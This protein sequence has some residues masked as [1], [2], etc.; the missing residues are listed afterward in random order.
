MSNLPMRVWMLR[1]F[2]RRRWKYP[3]F[4]TLLAGVI[5]LIGAFTATRKYESTTTILV[6][7]DQTLNP[8]SG[9]FDMAMAF[10]EQLRNFNEILFSRSTIRSLAD[11]L[12]LIQGR[13][14]EIQIQNVMMTVQ[15]NI[16][17]ARL[18]SDCFH[19]N[20]TDIVPVRAQRGAQ[21]LTS[22][23]IQTKLMVQTKQ[24]MLTVQFYEQK[25]IEY[26][27]DYEA[28]VVS[29]VKTMKQQVESMPVEARR[30]YSDMD[31][32]DRA[33]SSARSR[34]RLFE[35]KEK[36]LNSL[37]DEIR[38]SPELIRD[39]RGKQR[40]FDL[41][42][43]ELPYAADLR[44][45]AVQYDQVTQRYQGSYPEV[46]RLEAQIVDLL[47][48]MRAATDTEIKRLR[49]EE[50]NLEDRRS[51]VIEELKKSSVSHQQVQD[52]GS[53]YETR[54]RL[55]EEMKVRLEQARLAEEVASRGAHQFIVLDPAMVPVV[56]SKPNRMLIV[57]SGLV[58]G[59]LIGIVGAILAELLDTTLRS[60]RD[61]EV[62]EKP[63]IGL[64]PDGSLKPLGRWRG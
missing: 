38:V 53:I 18:G 64:L 27:R 59:L 30:L 55:F 50:T 17:T 47:I 29:M 14:P 42:R 46:E 23:F 10:E 13:M 58:V 12:G 5:C 22:L 9:Y 44:T 54:R 62:Y 43:T 1:S 63:V 26:K 28:S 49:Q 2:L 11:S 56:P 8:N 34:I 52:E 60:P 40:L 20:Y 32:L 7:P 57:L 48:R 39:G 21:V 36:T 35:E 3:V 24:N 19:I 45:L 61:V 33:I 16:S 4:A 15:G 6:R 51:Q 31:E 25:V 41:E 37:P